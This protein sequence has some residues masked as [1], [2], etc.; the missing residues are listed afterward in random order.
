MYENFIY[1]YLSEVL[2]YLEYLAVPHYDIDNEK[3]VF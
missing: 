2:E 1:M 3:D